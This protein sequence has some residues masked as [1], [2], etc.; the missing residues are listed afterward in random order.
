MDNKL[1][2]KIW[3]L[4]AYTFGIIVIYRFIIRYSDDWRWVLFG[5]FLTLM[6]LLHVFPLL[7]IKI[8]FP[9]S[10]KWYYILL[11]ALTIGILV[12]IIKIL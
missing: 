4:L 8:R 7:D 3:A 1:R 2:S 12:L 5:V 10:R 11:T 9:I 6:N